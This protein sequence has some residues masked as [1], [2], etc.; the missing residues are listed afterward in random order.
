MKKKEG[1]VNDFM[2]DFTIK[3]FLIISILLSVVSL[4]TFLFVIS[5]L[6]EMEKDIYSQ[7]ESQ[8]ENRVVRLETKVVGLETKPDSHRH[9]GIYGK[10]R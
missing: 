1:A 10:I 9:R 8:C 6:M 5:N 4:V 2:N 7:L 3:T